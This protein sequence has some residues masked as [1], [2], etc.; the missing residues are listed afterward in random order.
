MLSGELF[1]NYTYSI[2]SI[3]QALIFLQ[4]SHDYKTYNKIGP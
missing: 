2:F 3:N 4:D 1:S